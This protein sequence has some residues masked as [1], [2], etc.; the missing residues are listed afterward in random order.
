MGPRPIG[1]GNLALLLYREGVALGFNGA[2]PDRARKLPRIFFRSLSLITLQW[3]RARS[4][5]E[6]RCSNGTVAQS[7]WQLQWGRARSGAETQHR[8]RL[9]VRD[10]E[11]SM[12]PRPIGRGNAPRHP[13]RFWRPGCFNG[14]A[15][16]RA[17]KLGPGPGAWRGAPARFNGAAP[18]RARKL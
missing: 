15:P 10:A 7:W 4:G 18:D 17:R 3:G 5:A 12:G 13:F 9:D 14:A 2:A 16:D 1:R 11:A 6:T 8:R